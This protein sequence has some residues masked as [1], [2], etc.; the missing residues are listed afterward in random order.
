VKWEKFVKKGKSEEA[1]ARAL[2]AIKLQ[3]QQQNTSAKCPKRDGILT[4][5]TLDNVQFTLNFDTFAV[6]GRF[7][8]ASFSVLKS[9]SCHFASL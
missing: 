2:P 8:D 9:D 4:K 3:N 5:A 7:Y 6:C 1:S